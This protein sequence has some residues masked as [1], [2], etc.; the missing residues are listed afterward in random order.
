MDWGVGR[1]VAPR[2]RIAMMQVHYIYSE[3]YFFYYYISSTSDHQALDLGGWGSVSY[4]TN[5]LKSFFKQCFERK[6]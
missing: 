5:C 2:G 3:F 1:R 6:G 4:K